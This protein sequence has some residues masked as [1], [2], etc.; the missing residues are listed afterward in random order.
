MKDAL[1]IKLIWQNGFFKSF[2]E[3]L[4]PK[5]QPVGATAS[6][7]GKRINPLSGP[8]VKRDNFDKI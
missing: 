4:A 3:I 5:K 2:R 1:D 8:Y 6:T 7:G